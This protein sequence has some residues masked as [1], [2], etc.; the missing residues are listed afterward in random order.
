M[1]EFFSK[2]CK[3]CVKKVISHKSFL[4]QRHEDSPAVY[5][6]DPFG[7]H[8]YNVDYSLNK[9]RRWMMMDELADMVEQVQVR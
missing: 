4:Y 6:D 5:R 2:K 9:K 3:K 8:D 7:V 1:D